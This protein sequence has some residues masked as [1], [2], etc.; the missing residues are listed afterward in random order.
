M[1]LHYQKHA[2]EVVERF[3]QM[4][5]DDQVDVITEEHFQELETLITAALGVVHS[6]VSHKA[7]KSL[8]NVARELRQEANETD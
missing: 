7:A 5:S 2:K 8:E 1:S 3:Q 6:E 4:L